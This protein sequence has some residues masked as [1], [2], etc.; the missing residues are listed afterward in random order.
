MKMPIGR[1]LTCCLIVIAMQACST[2]PPVENEPLTS[3]IDLSYQRMALAEPAAR[4]KWDQHKPVIDPIHEKASLESLVQRAPGNGVDPA[5]ARQFF[6]ELVDGV[7]SIEYGYYR[8]WQVSAPQGSPPDL[9][10]V[11]RPEQARLENSLMKALAR[12]QPIRATP[13]CA[14]RL[15]ESLASWKAATAFDE[16]RSTG[17]DMALAH[18]CATSGR[19]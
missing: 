10:N 3:L 14:A 7:N 6:S 9:V 1:I 17:L 16:R 5:F 13:D 2:A 15:S 12:V 18:V 19:G 4:A 8:Q 11:V